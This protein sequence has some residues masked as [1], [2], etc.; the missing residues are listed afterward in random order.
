LFAIAALLFL[1]ALLFAWPFVPFVAG[2][3]GGVCLAD[4][5]RVAKGEVMY[6]DFF[7]FITPGTALFY[8]SMIKIFG[9]RL[10][11]PNVTLA[12]LGLA[13]AVAGVVIAKKIMRP[14]LALLPSA[15]FLE[16]LYKNALDPTHHSFS[17]LAA[18][19]SI[20]VLMERRST[21]RILAAGAFA[22]LAMCFTQAR[23]LGVAVGLAVFL[24]WESRHRSEPWRALGRKGLA[25]AVGFLGVTTAVNVYFVW[26]AGLGRFLWSTVW[27]GLKY[28]PQQA[29]H[30]TFR[31]LALSLHPVSG[32]GGADMAR[33]LLLYVILTSTPIMVFV[34]YAREARERPPAFWEC[35]MLL[36]IVAV[37]MLV[38]VSPSPAANRMIANSMPGLILL[39]WLL[40]SPGKL[41]RAI[42]ALLA[43]GILFGVPY[44]AFRAEKAPKTIVTSPLGEFACALPSEAEE[45][46]WIVQHTRPTD[47]FFAALDPKVYFYLGLRNPSPLPF[48]TN[49]GYTTTQQVAEVIRG[50]EQ[51]RPRYIFWTHRDREGIPAWE[52]PA[53]DHL[54]PV[55]DYKRAH[56]RLVKTFGDED[57]IWERSD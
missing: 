31:A 46:R 19:L 11:I 3:D 8:A 32:H 34:R 9:L 40:D 5:V 1:Y 25:L 52:N 13:I 29:D 12:F 49:N 30:N 42:A 24:W 22:G 55:R 53:D 23:G 26:K 57:E 21:G 15:V 36:A 38:S 18:T 44:S 17:M 35:P 45:Y 48:L 47:F 6:R 14:S 41:A 51:H 10:W 54:G 39:G 20:L 33:S 2:H 28:Y 56:Y 27:F 4:G 16:G 37:F 50:L 43:A 7:Q